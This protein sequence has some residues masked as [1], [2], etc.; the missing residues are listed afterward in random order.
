MFLL[1]PV[2]LVGM[3]LETLS[4]GM[5]VPAL[6][7]LMNETY[8]DQF[9]SFQLVFEYFGN[10][11]HEKLIFLGLSGLAV[12]YILKNIFLFYQVHCQGTF[13]Y[14]TQR[15]IG[16][17]LFRKYLNNGYMFHLQVNSSKLI[18]NLTTEINSY[19]GF[20]LMPTIN[21]LTES[22][23]IFAILTLVFW[24]EPQGTIFLIF[25][26]RFIGLLVC[27]SK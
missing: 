23:V 26:L 14:S 15:E 20:F 9:P 5:V 1:L 4:V 7:I 8:F 24:V 6:G 19:C 3:V 13:V 21:L 12:T 27:Q 10:P 16:V 2:I 25:I 18:R 22:L 17:Q 11:S